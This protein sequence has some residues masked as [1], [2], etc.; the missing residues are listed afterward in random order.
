MMNS[1]KLSFQ[2]KIKD[3]KNFRSRNIFPCLANAVKYMNLR[4]FLF[5]KQY[6]IYS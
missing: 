4:E 5:I 2:F 3:N 1:F 6:L